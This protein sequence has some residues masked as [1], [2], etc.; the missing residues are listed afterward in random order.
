VQGLEIIEFSRSK[1]DATAK[2]LAD[3][4]DAV[5]QLGLIK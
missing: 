5:L 4:R 3:E 2:E 1:M